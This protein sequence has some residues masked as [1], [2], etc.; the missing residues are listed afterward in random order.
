MRFAVFVSLLIFTTLGAT[1]Y[2]QDVWT[3]QRCVQYAIDHNISI[4]QDVLN[5]R[6]ARYTLLQS[7]LAQLPT[8]NSTGAY[9][10]SFGR[11]INP[12]TN[13]FVDGGYDYLSLTG[14]ANVLLFGWFAQRNT[15]NR[16]KFSLDASQADLDQLKDDVSLNVATG[17]LRAILAKEQI[18]VSEKQ[19]DLSKAQLAQT[20]SFANAGRLPELNVAQLESQL[21]GD[22]SNLI[23]A[24]ANYTASILDLKTLL[25][26]DFSAP[27]DIEAP[28]VKVDDEM[29]VI[30]TK[31]EEI[32]QEAHKHFGSIRGSE[33][34][35]AAAEKGVALYKGNLYPQLSL[36][37]QAGTNWASNYLTAQYSNPHLTPIGFTRNGDTVFQPGYDIATPVIPFGKQFDNNFRQTVALNLNVPLF[38]GW[39]SQYAVRQAR[40]NLATQ[41]LNEYN[42][43]L[44]LK[45]NV[46][47]AHNDAI[48]SIQKY[49][50]AVRAADAAQRALD[51]AKKRYDLGLTTTVDFL[52]TQ[53]SEYTAASNLLSARYD[54]I[55]KLKVIDYY[56]GKELKL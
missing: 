16:N 31:P 40:I 55:F 25:N 14:S 8:V 43:E 1:V 44:T 12:T 7:Q 38:N 47:K 50:A 53:N 5:K 24:I 34:R 56:L 3:L 42:A 28:D 48:S 9:G 51:F 18:H 23:T 54:L 17:F 19:V 20:V 32:Y 41:Q 35:V 22:S 21:A 39:Q 33:D 29:T 49:A 30:T 2:G 13:Q 46:Y 52:V 26:L 37:V 36:S 6:L 10:K 15:I 27:F 45:Q 4:Q 11:S